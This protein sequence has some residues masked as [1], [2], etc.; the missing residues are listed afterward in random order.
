MEEERLVTVALE[1]SMVSRDSAESRAK[2][3]ATEM[4]KTGLPEVEPLVAGNAGE[5][6]R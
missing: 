3:M 2:L 5:H 1:D 6:L 4:R